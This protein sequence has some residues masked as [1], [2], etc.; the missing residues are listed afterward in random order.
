MSKATN[1]VL[2][3]VEV[4]AKRHQQEEETRQQLQQ[5]QETRQQQQQEHIQTGE[6][7]WHSLSDG[8]HKAKHIENGETA[9]SPLVVCVCRRGNDSQWVVKKLQEELR[10]QLSEGELQRVHHKVKCV[11]I[12]GG[13]HA[14]ARHID[15]QFPI[16]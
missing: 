4:L 10:R 1:Q 16:Y 6:D 7:V 8:E 14:W 2:Q 9:S 11:D 12:K 5:E 3:E 13:L 15:D